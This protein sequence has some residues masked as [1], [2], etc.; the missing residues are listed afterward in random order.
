MPLGNTDL[1]PFRVLLAERKRIPQYQRDFVWEVNLITTFLENIWDAFDDGKEQYFCGSLVVFQAKDSEVYEIVDGQQRT[2]VLYT[3]ISLMIGKVGELIE[4]PDFAG[5]ERIKHIYSRN[6]RDRR[7]KEYHYS[8]RHEKIRS[9]YE[10]IGMGE[11]FSVTG[12]NDIATKTLSSCRE[13]VANFV[14]LKIESSEIT[15][16]TD[17]YYY[18]LDKVK[19]THFIAADISEALLVYSRLNS[20]GK[21]LGYLEIIKGQLF[22]SVQNQQEEKW[23]KL[24]LLWNDFWIKFKTP[25]KI[26]GYGTARDLIGDETFLAYYF[27]VHHAHLVNKKTSV[28]DGFLQSKRM[29]DFLLDSQVKKE[30]FSSPEDFLNSLITFVDLMI[31][32]RIGEHD[33]ETCKNDLI[34]L[35]LLSQTQTQP[36]MFLL[37]CSY[38]QKLLKAMLPHAM[39]LVFIFTMSVTGTGSTSNAWKTLAKEVRSHRKSHNSD[40]MI[41]ILSSKIKGTIKQYWKSNFIPFV[42]NCSLETDRRK[43]KVVLLVTEMAARREAK[44]ADG[45]NYHNYYFK[46]GYDLDHLT[47]SAISQEDYVQSIGNAALLGSAVN[48][49]LKAIA[50]ENE[51]KRK[52]LARSDIATTRAL[53][54]ESS[55][56]QGANKAIMLMFSTIEELNNETAIN[57]RNELIDC[58]YR[59]IELD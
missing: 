34:D 28:N 24:E 57:R 36:L 45:Q 23:D 12:S 46:Q 15:K 52:A 26:G 39:K 49:S 29:I 35:A 50:F 58:L 16:F 37:S 33:D 1:T 2:T 48:R 30:V 51:N 42:E 3:L 21:P 32:Y 19:F 47:P 9:F 55:E 18:I 43:I 40:E 44:L 13:E 41:T 5:E 17:F 6:G 10:A 53:I 56:E 4:D 25:I 11:D 54:L 31:N 59:F 22:E 38:D 20:G 7:T 8:H 27:L 14:Q